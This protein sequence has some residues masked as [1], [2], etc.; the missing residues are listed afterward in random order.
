MAIAV[1]YVIYLTDATKVQTFNTNYPNGVQIPPNSAAATFGVPGPAQGTNNLNQTGGIGIFPG[2][3]VGFTPDLTGAYNTESFTVTFPDTYPPPTGSGFPDPYPITLSCYWVGTFA[4]IGQANTAP[5]SGSTSQRYL[6]NRFWANGFEVPTLGDGASTGN[7]GTAK[8][9][10]ASRTLEGMGF[11]YRNEGNGANATHVYPAS[12]LVSWQRFYLRLRV[13]PTGGDDNVAFIHGTGA[14]GADFLL[15][16]NTSGTLQGYFKG[17]AA[18]PGASAGVSTALTVGTWYRIDWRTEYIQGSSAIAPAAMSVYINGVLSFTGSDT[19]PNIAFNSSHANANLG[20]DVSATLH[21]LECD[22][23]DWIGAAEVVITNKDGS[24]AKFP[25]MDLTSGSHVV[26]VRPT[27]FGTAHQTANWVDVNALVTGDWREV[28]T[29]PADPEGVFSGLQT[30]TSGSILQVTTDYA[31]QQSGV[32]CIS[33]AVFIKQNGGGTGKLQIS[34]SPTVNSFTQAAGWNGV[35]AAYTVSNGA[36]A[37]ALSDPGAQ[38]ITFTAGTATTGVTGLFATAEFIGSWGPE[39]TIAAVPGFYDVRV[40]IHNSPYPDTQ[41]NHSRFPPISAVRV[42]SGVYVGNN[43]GQDLFE[44]IPAHWYWVRPLT[45]NTDGVFWFSSMEA[46]HGINQQKIRARGMVEAVLTNQNRPKIEISGSDALSNANTARFQFVAVEDMGMR[47][48]INGAFAHKGV[49]ASFANTLVDGA[50]TPD[51]LFLMKEDLASGALGAYFK[52][53]GNATDTATG[54]DNLTGQ[55]A[56]IASMAAGSIT[57]KTT[58]H[59]DAPQT[60]FSAWRKADGSGAAQWF[61]TGS[62]TGTGGASQNIALVLG[63]KLPQFVLVVAHNG[64]TFARDPS[65]TGTN[66]WQIGSGNSTTGITAIA[67]NQF[68]AGSSINALG[69]VYEFFAIQGGTSTV[70]GFYTVAGEAVRATN[71]PWSAAPVQ[72]TISPVTLTTPAQWRV[73]RFDLEKRDEEES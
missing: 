46:A 8:G 5:P 28:N 18:Y 45:A 22:F 16:I 51:C 6:G 24:T 33:V 68:T 37:D 62:Y 11:A 12:T 55:V 36:T 44:N 66:S 67:A 39:D 31:R 69:I 57:S 30:S 64:G 50:F 59:T 48:L 73:H 26:L 4:Y 20:E 56:G 14:A 70:N 49:L 43:I 47:Y 53:P 63:G 58:I 2:D 42:S 32:A 60:A 38:N 13:L 19:T 21:G 27:G 7:A 17:N 1:H 65:H 54:M 35:S 25:G 3:S 40:G 10:D 15:N 34:A 9:R 23:D 71:G 29:N 41:P 72:G 61:D 52:G